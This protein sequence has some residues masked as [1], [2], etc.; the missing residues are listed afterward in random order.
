MR[1]KRKY[2]FRRIIVSFAVCIFLMGFIIMPIKNA[3][4]Q[5]ISNNIEEISTSRYPGIKEAVKSIKASH[6]N[7]NFKILYTGLDWHDVIQNE[8]TGHNATPTNLIPANSNTYNNNWICSIC[9]TKTYD[10]G[11]WHCASES[12]IA[13]MMD[14]R[15]FLD[16]SNIFQFLELSYTS[17]NYEQILN[18]VS[19][20][21]LNKTSVIDTII[22]SAKT[23][24]VNP[25][26]IIARLIQEQGKA[27]TELVAGN[28]Y[29]GNYVGYY[30]AFNIGATG[31]T[32]ADVILNGLKRA[33]KE[34]WTSLEASIRGGVRIISKNYIARGQNTLYLQKFDV[35]ISDGTLYTH[36]YMQNLLAA[37]NE[38]AQITKVMKNI[39]MDN[40][41]TFVI[42]VYENMPQFTKTEPNLKY[43][44]IEELVKVNVTGN[45]RIRN[46]PSGGQTIGWLNGEDIITRLEKAESKVNGTY[47]DKVKS[48]SGIYGYVARE[49]Y[50]GA[51]E[52]KLYLV[53]VEEIKPEQPETPKPEETLPE[54][55]ENNNPEGEDEE[56]GGE[57]NN[58]EGEEGDN[59]EDNSG[60]NE[61]IIEVKIGDV[62][63]DG[64][65]S[66]TDY[67]LI[68]NHIMQIKVL[69]TDS[70]KKAADVNKDG[71]ISATDY[72]LIKNHIMYGTEIK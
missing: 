49:T 19:G 72:V 2:I 60:E 70:E 11:D 65:I 63:N 12:A 62:N 55:G 10:T 59:N 27:G 61:E 21:Y 24:N 53:P 50:E 45:L 9:G 58:P 4:T 6:P 26:Y 66:P 28:G 20:S 52:Y 41:Y 7:W 23:Y 13:Y 3:A 71:K 32:R 25:Y 38:A 30:N 17:Y 16:D 5:V 47:W 8:Y 67:V 29:N 54:N 48:A 51:Q 18:M 35:E 14:P 37:K 15:N 22:D 57:N 40:S 46:A 39:G 44:E 69:L 42:P 68:K 56:N 36:Q 64:K 43:T 33:Q 34:G 31:N 1:K